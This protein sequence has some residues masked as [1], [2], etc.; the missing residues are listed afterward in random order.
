MIELQDALQQKF[1][2]NKSSLIESYHKYRTYYD[3]KANANPLKLHTFCLILNRKLS[4]QS[5][6]GSKSMHVWIPLYRVEKVLTNSNYLIRK[7]GTN[8]T[9]S[10]HRIRLR[11]YKPTEAPVDLEDISPDNFV[12]DPV[13]GKYR[14]EPEM[15]DDEIP[16]LLEHT[17]ISDV[18]ERIEQ[19]ETQPVTTT[20]NYQIAV[21]AVAAPRPVPPPAAPLPPAVH[22]PPPVAPPRQ[23]P[24]P[25]ELPNF[26]EPPN[27][28]LES[29]S[30]FEMEAQENQDPGE[31]VQPM[32]NTGGIHEETDFPF[33]DFSEPFE[34]HGQRPMTNQQ[35]SPRIRHESSLETP[36]SQQNVNRRVTFHP[37]STKI[38]KPAVTPSTRKVIRIPSK[39]G[40]IVIPFSNLSRGEKRKKIVESSRDSTKRLAYQ[41]GPSRATKL[42]LKRS[43]EVIE[44]DKDT[45]STSSST[46]LTPKTTTKTQ[47]SQK[48]PSP[49]YDL[50][51]GAKRRTRLN[52]PKDEQKND[53][54]LKAL[55]NSEIKF[56]FSKSNISEAKCSIVQSVSVENPFELIDQIVP[57]TSLA[58]NSDLV[59]GS[60]ILCFDEKQKRF[61]YNLVTTISKN[62]KA[63]YSNLQK[64]LYNLSKHVDE[65]NID[66]LALPQM[67]CSKE[68]LEWSQVFKIITETFKKSNMQLYFYVA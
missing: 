34:H 1:A 53:G 19:E 47:S 38:P 51:L 10:L 60:L 28:V 61:I 67:E 48:Q 62:A 25:E 14:Q 12:P 4:H 24:E 23:P 3:A 49:L 16:K 58:K 44:S 2:E 63:S 36:I 13:L 59:E 39:D 57:C 56:Y 41:Q 65:H 6:F 30:D 37:D 20:L 32:I 9:Q 11:P 21:P 68:G 33:A 54:Q 35:I 46:Q 64:C 45:P 27:I 43:Q 31:E 29:D 22:P 55:Y 52:K 50:V 15:F 42:D 66:K 8:F 7:V 5:D 26:P 17:F 40:K 18:P